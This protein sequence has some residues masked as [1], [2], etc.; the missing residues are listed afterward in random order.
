MLKL[1]SADTGL[2]RG[3][4]V[5]SAAVRTGSMRSARSETDERGLLDQCCGEE[6]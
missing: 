1:N 4:R 2:S 6:G 3:P 5:P